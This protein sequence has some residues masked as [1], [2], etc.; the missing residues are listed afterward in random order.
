MAIIARW[1]EVGQL[2]PRAGL[3]P[4]WRITTQLHQLRVQV[5]AA[6]GS[7]ERPH[8]PSLEK[9]FPEWNLL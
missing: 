9:T 5:A 1:I 3:L 4:A 6:I 8:P 2:G 7:K